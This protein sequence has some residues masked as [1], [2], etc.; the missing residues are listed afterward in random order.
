MTARYLLDSNILSDLIRNPQ[1]KVALRVEAVG[2]ASVCTSIIVASE[3]RYGLARKGSAALAA[4]A[5]PV[6]ARIPIRPLEEPFD[7][8]Y[9]AVRADL[10]RRGL[11][12][13]HLDCLIA[14][15]AL[16]LDCTIV[17]ANEREFSRVAGLS[18]ENWLR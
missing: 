13:G 16:A 5:E 17:T 7:E 3:I 6:L 12:I 18:L 10:D 4:K 8:I 1:G 9:G 11:P 15:H 2:D 14:A